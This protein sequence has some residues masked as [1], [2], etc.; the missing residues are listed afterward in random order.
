[1][2]VKKKA[3][4]KRLTYKDAGVNIDA[5][6]RFVDRL[7]ELTRKTRDGRVISD[8]RHFAGMYQLDLKGMEEPVLVAT[9]DGVGTK[10]R[11]A[12][13]T[14]RHDSVGVDLVAMCANDLITCGAKPLLFLDYF[15]TGEFEHEQAVELIAGIVDGCKQAGMVLIGGETAEM[16]G[17]YKKGEYDLAGFAN[18]IVDRKKIIDGTR[19]APGD[20]VLG[21]KSSG[22]HSNGY[23]LA[24]KVLLD[25]AK[26]PL[27]KKP[28]GFELTLGDTLLEP[29]RI[30][31]QL[32][33]KLLA[34]HDLKGIAHI[35]GGGLPDNIRR[36][37]PEG[38]RVTLERESWE[39][40]AIF[41][42]IEKL[43]NVPAGDMYRTFNMGIG[44][45]LIAD[46][47]T[48]ARMERSAPEPLI[49]IGRVEEG[50]TDVVLA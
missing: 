40:P 11:V 39:V 14:G 10:L 3:P 50:D 47:D 20:V 9:T 24:R 30:Y 26:L 21:V 2:S 34:L 7:G 29:T 6:D 19:I 13:L 22:L 4:K 25:R 18:G 15:A 5:T 32:V 37:L 44:L 17:F 41:R 49:R 36:L 43:G 16:P 42:L 33:T 8:F 38:C 23:S 46:A 48:A 45:A 1:V 27:G 31:V 35:T 12:H 28:K